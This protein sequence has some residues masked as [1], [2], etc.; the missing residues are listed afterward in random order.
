MSFTDWL[1]GHKCFKC[2]TRENVNHKEEMPTMEG[3]IRFWYCD[4]CYND[5]LEELKLKAEGSAKGRAK[6]IKEN[7]RDSYY[8]WLKREIEIIELEKKAE[9]LGFKFKDRYNGQV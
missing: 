2:A 9:Q 5:L 6:Q 1:Y 4:D 3:T 7:E 8:M